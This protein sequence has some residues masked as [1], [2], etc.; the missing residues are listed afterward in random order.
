MF[1]LKS[2]SLG[3]ILVEP[4]IRKNVRVRTMVEM[5]CLLYGCWE[6]ERGKKERD[7]IEKDTGI[8]T[9]RKGERKGRNN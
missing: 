1:W 3:S 6:G 7:R 9:Q 2:Q 8:K 4:V 5:S